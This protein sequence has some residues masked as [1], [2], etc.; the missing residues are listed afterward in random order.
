MKI[1]LIVTGLLLSVNAFAGIVLIGNPASTESLT[2]AQA[3]SL[4]LGKSKKLPS[5]EKALLLEFP[6]GNPLKIQFHQQV[7]GKD[8]AQLKSYWARLIFTGKAKPPKK[9][10]NTNMVKSAVASNKGAVGY[11]EESE[12]DDSVNVLLK[13]QFGLFYLIA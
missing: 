1:L 13:F 8:E 4:F 2:V 9:L 6:Q 12:V 3:K 5:G 11:I 7:T 10:S